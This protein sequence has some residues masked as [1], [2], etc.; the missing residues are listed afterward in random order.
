VILKSVFANAW[1]IPRDYD[2]ERSETGRSVKGIF[3]ISRCRSNCD[4]P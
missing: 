3:A 1:I 4:W 2:G